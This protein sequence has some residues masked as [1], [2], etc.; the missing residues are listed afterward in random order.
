MQIH[1]FPLLTFI[2]FLPL[3][4]ASIILM[5]GETQA[6][7]ARICSLVTASIQLLLCWPLLLG[8]DLTQTAMQWQEQARWIPALKISYH[9]G[10]DG[11]SLTLLVLSIFMHFIIMLSS[12]HLIKENVACY[13]AAFL[14]MQSMINGVFCAMDSILFY[15]FWEG[16]LIPMFLCIGMFGSSN[17]NYDSF[18]AYVFSIN[19]FWSKSLL[20]SFKLLEIIFSFL[21]I[22]FL[23]VASLLYIGIKY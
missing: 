14:V 21:D 5:R 17:R 23:Y 10:V 7:F 12:W 22:I 15:L 6:Q 3:L 1:S 4:S 2:I 16:M 9:L 18:Y 8:F 19:L 20:S 13:S 11:L